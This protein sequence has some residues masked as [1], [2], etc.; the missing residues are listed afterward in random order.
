MVAICPKCPSMSMSDPVF[1]LLAYESWRLL[2]V[3]VVT[4]SALFLSKGCTIV[5][6]SLRF[7]I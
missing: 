7:S 1:R 5:C 6:D 2:M 4:V 3:T